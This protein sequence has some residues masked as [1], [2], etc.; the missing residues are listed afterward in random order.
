MIHQL[1]CDLRPETVGHRTQPVAQ[2]LVECGGHTLHYRLGQMMMSIDQ[3]RPDYAAAGV[4]LRF[5]AID[6][7]A[8]IAA[9]FGNPPVTDTNIRR[10]GL[11]GRKYGFGVFDQISHCGAPL[12]VKEQCPGAGP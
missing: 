11:A 10:I 12:G 6:G 3:P 7:G 2:A 1:R 5:S 8:Q 4:D 9:H